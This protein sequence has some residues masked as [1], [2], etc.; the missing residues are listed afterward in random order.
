MRGIT[1]FSLIAVVFLG[2]QLDALADQ[3]DT[4][5]RLINVEDF[6]KTVDVSAPRLSPAGE[7]VAYASSGQI[8]V[9]S[10][11]GGSPRA[12]TAAASGAG[13]SLIIAN[14]GH[15]I[16]QKWYNWELGGPWENRAMYDRLSPLASSGSG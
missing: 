8:Y 6:A 15:D 9:V 3:S 16:Y 5:R 14:Y 7:Q 13:H 2:L 11:S 10:A 12:V 4:S 1:G